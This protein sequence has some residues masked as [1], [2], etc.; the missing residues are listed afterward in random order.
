M[1]KY[2]GSKGT[3]IQY[4][5]KPQFDKIIEPFAGTARYALRYFDRD[6]LLVDKY[7]LLINIW[8]WLQKCSPGDIRKLPRLKMGENIDDFNFDCEEAKN[9]VGFT[10]GFMTST[11][12]KTGT[13]K[14]K[15]RPNFANFTLT[16][17]EKSLYKIRHWQIECMS[18]DEIEN[19]KATWFI[20]PPYLAGGENYVHSNKDIDYCHLANWCKSRKGQSIVCETEPA[21][22]L[23]FKPMRRHK[24]RNGFQYE[25][26]WS[27]MPTEFDNEQLK[28]F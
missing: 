18:Y 28:I 4:Y 27:N 8:K 9:L 24:T 21:N 14:L 23:P 5:P 1:W 7:E 2:F 3:I 11:P 17:I 16:K 10:I 20:D 6:V 15:E 12:R 22:W 25:L 13:I 26:I 19:Q